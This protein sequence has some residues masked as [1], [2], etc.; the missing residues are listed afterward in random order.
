[1]NKL[2]AFLYT[3]RTKYWECAGEHV[4]WSDFRDAF[5]EYLAPQ[6]RK[7]WTDDYLREQLRHCGCP[8]GP[9]PQNRVIVGNVSDQRRTPRRFVMTERGVRLEKN[10]I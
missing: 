6:Y 1:M 4:P 5:V 3:E 8:V 2:E 7:R 9:G 10:S